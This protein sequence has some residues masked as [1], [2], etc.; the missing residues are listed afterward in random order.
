MGDCINPSVGKLLHAYETDGL[1]DHQRE[2]FELHLFQCDHCMKEVSEFDRAASLMRDDGAV[3]DVIARAV[4]DSGKTEAWSLKLLKLLWPKTNPFLRPAV[5]YAVVMLL[6]YPAYIGLRSTDSGDIRE[7][8]TLNLNGTRSSTSE[9]FSAVRD[10]LIRFRFHGAESESIYR[11]TITSETAEVVFRNDSFAGFDESE[12]GSLLIPAG[13]VKP[14]R[15]T[16][17]VEDPSGEPPLNLQEYYFT[18][19]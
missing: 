8:Q 9:T 10:V 18:I 5:I 1:S 15:F 11:V 16:L 3:H 17:K 6:L 13:T 4:K 7:V 19:Q 12:V 14:G 2:D